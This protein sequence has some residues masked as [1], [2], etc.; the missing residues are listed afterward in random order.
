MK[1]F[2]QQEDIGYTSSG[3]GVANPSNAGPVKGAK[4]VAQPT[5]VARVKNKIDVKPKTPIPPLSENRFIER[6]HSHAVVGFARMNPPTIGHEALVQKVRSHAAL[7]GGTPHVFLSHSEGNKHNPISYKEKLDMARNAFG[8]VVHDTEAKNPYDIA[9][10][11][12]GKYDHLTIVAGSDRL[13]EYKKY[14][15]SAHAK[16][17]DFKYKT[18]NFVSSGD[19]NPDTKGVVG[20]SSSM[21]RQHAINGNHRAFEAGLPTKLRKHADKIMKTVHKGIIKEWLDESFSPDRKWSL[22]D[23]DNGPYHKEKAV[24][25]NGVVHKASDYNHDDVTQKTRSGVRMVNHTAI[26][27]AAGIPDE[28]STPGF[29]GHD[30]KFYDYD[31]FDKLAT[32]HM[33]KL[34]GYPKLGSK[35]NLSNIST[36]PQ[37][38]LSSF[39]NQKDEEVALI[40]MLESY[41][42]HADIKLSDKAEKNL[43]EK[44]EK[45]GILLTDLKDVYQAAID[46]W[47]VKQDETFLL[48]EQWAF[49]KVN[50]YINQLEMAWGVI[51]NAGRGDWDKE[52]TEW[53]EAAKRWRDDYFK[54]LKENVD[55]YK[56]KCEP[57]DKN[58]S[59]RS[60]G[61]G[62]HKP[63]ECPTCKTPLKVVEKISQGSYYKEENGAGFVG[64]SKLTK[65]YAKVTPGQSGIAIVKNKYREDN[66][67][68]EEQ[69]PQVKGKQMYKAFLR[70]G[71]EHKR[72]AGSHRIMSKSGKG[73]FVLCHG[74]NDEIHSPMVAKIVKQS[75]LNPDR[76]RED[77]FVKPDPKRFFVSDTLDNMVSPFHKEKAI[78]MGDKIHRQ[79]D[80]PA[81]HVT[82][83][84]GPASLRIAYHY[85]IASAALGKKGE[86]VPSENHPPYE[87][88]FIGH[89]NK[90]YSEQEMTKFANNH[91]LKHGYPEGFERLRPDRHYSPLMKFHEFSEAHEQD[92]DKEARRNRILKKTGARGTGSNRRRQLDSMKAFE[93]WKE[94]EHKCPDKNHGVW[95]HEIPPKLPCHNPVFHPCEKCIAFEP[96]EGSEFSHLKIDLTSRKK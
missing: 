3:T 53:Q 27:K 90:Y 41:L 81:E 31:H 35:I 28:H 62:W 7:V 17:K 44:S 16:G 64:T 79:S 89:N 4:K 9:K 54:T 84:E 86:Y 80:F 73:T 6:P 76:L 22:F 18:L 46:D 88:G 50:R 83:K 71:W 39:H 2:L 34:G 65:K 56:L 59:S 40:G 25:Y 57:C 13:P 92:L 1:T 96:E 74:D 49:N 48:P 85:K 20:I 72:T 19:R 67:V 30:D 63:H 14:F 37:S 95:T 32:A 47:Y 43:Q 33:T 42:D 77:K 61:Q 75:G 93:G 94:C 66:F 36:K 45:C 24:S 12:S 82:D 11:F 52:S 5:G 15:E 87:R 58:Y 68:S 51:A 60:S 38:S 70:D 55:V 23:R 91:V 78:K 26:E 10:D 21:M 29:I 8:D 69:L